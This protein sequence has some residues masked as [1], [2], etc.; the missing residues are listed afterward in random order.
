MRSSNKA[1]AA[2]CAAAIGMVSVAAE[3]QPSAMV[4]DQPILLGEPYSVA[5][6]LYRPAD[7]AAYDEVGY[8]MPMEAGS[9]GELTANGEAFVADAIT[10]AHKTLPLPSYVEVTALDSGR[11]ILVR[12]NDRGPMRNDRLIGLSPGAVAQLGLSGPSAAVRVRRV[13]PPGQD[14]VAL[15][16]HERAAERLESPPALLK[17]LR[18]KLQQTRL[19]APVAQAPMTAAPA[20]AGA[21]FDRPQ[22]RPV[23]TKPTAAAPASKEQAASGRYFIQVGAFSSRANAEALAKRIGAQVEQGG[24]LWRVRFG[25][26]ATRQAAQAGVRAAAAQGFANMPVM[27]KD[28]R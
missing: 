1:F 27:A 25:P 6:V 5:G 11:T 17:V 23:T 18:E 24:N 3:A 28:G 15:R 19:P 2:L 26:Y 13:N 8:A 20:R 4:E 7:P 16:S 12:V 21:T 9:K 14:Q 10:G 22:P